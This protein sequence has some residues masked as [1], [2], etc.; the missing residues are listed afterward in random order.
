VKEEFAIV[1][2]YKTG[3][4]IPNNYNF[5]LDERGYFHSFEEKIGKEVYSPA[6]ETYCIEHATKGGIVYGYTFFRIIPKTHYLE[7]K[8][9]FN[10]WA[11][12]ISSIFLILTIMYYIFSKETAKVFG[13][14]L[15]CF[16]TALLILFVILTYCTFKPKLNV[17]STMTTCKIIGKY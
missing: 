11:M 9:L 10:R 8:F 16:C 3:V 4:Y 7:K 1:H 17:R 14:T 12:V 5:Y 2:G 15:I 6:Q 13:K